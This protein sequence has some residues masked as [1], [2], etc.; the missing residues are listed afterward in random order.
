[1]PALERG[2]KSREYT[3]NLGNYENIKIAATIEWTAE[4]DEDVS[5]VQQWADEMLTNLTTEELRTAYSLTDSDKSFT[6][7]L[8]TPPRKSRNGRN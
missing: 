2:S 6:L 8:F 3:V 7:D 5:E 1:M 4:E